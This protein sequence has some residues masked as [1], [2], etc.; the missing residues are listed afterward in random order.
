MIDETSLALAQAFQRVADLQSQVHFK[1][2]DLQFGGE[3]LRHGY[4]K[5]A[6]LD[7]A[8]Q[9]LADLEAELETAVRELAAQLAAWRA[10]S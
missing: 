4:I 7:A 9:K 1:Q 3:S 10:K 2:M 6:D 5:Q 8:K